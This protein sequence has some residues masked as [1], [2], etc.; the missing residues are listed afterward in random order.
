M[1]KYPANPN[2]RVYFDEFDLSGVLNSMSLSIDQATPVVT[3]LSDA[4]PRRI[5]GGYSSL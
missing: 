2:S 3:C 1:A 5:V 4:G